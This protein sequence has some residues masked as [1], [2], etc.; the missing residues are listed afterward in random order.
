[1]SAQ[2]TPTEIS[3]AGESDIQIR[4]SDGKTTIYPARYLRLNCPC[5]QCVDEMSGRQVLQ[6][7]SIPQNIRPVGIE[8]VGRYAISIR[9]SDGHSTG[10]YTWEWLHKL[11]GQLP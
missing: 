7:S 6:E 11:A 1:M 10:I 2:P 9:W 8:P 3:R 5:A 4:W